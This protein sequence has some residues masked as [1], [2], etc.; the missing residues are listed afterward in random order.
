M[1]HG[2]TG[3]SIS[4]FPGS[5][6]IRPEIFQE[7]IYDILK[8]LVRTGF[9]NI[10]IINGHGGNTEPMQKAITK[11]HMETGAYFMIISWW[12]AAW[13]LAEAVNRWEMMETWK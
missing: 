10:L 3:A 2:V 7:Y 13:N 12:E 9:K 1:N 5:I 11:L 6:M 4:Q 8:D